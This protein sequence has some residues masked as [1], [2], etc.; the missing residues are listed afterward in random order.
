MHHY[1]FQFLYLTA[2]VSLSRAHSWIDCLDTDESVVYEKS[3]EWVYGGH[4]GNGL[5]MGYPR[6]YP[7]RG[8]ADI[9]PKFTY[10]LTRH[11]V[12][13]GAPVCQFRDGNYEGWRTMMK[14][15]PGVPVYYGYLPNGHIAKDKMG[16]G[17]PANMYWSGDVHK[18]LSSTLELNATTL[19][20]GFRDFDDERCGESFEDLNGLHGS[21]RAGDGKP[22]VG[23]FTI[24][25][26]TKPGVYQVVWFW[27][28]YIEGAIGDTL[29]ARGYYN[30]AYSTCMDILV[31]EED[32][33]ALC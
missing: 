6:Q 33:H 22:C 19:L 7:G 13:T 27:K 14:V 11:Q 30:S 23:S 24:P 15:K 29:F 3:A 16:R 1:I 28:F 26:G 18:E 25:E 17:T 8:D 9:N 2:F 21:G 31:E 4:K 32:E 10:Q 5:C 12:E 20:G